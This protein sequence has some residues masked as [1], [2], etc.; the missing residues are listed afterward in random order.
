MKN[1][2]AL[3]LFSFINIAAQQ[4]TLKGTVEN[5]VTGEQL[6]FASIRIEG[7]SN[8]T[9]TNG[10]GNY[11]FKLRPGVYRFIASYIGF[12]SDTLK[13]NLQ[14]DGVYNFKLDPKGVNIAEIT[15]LPEDNPANEV[16]RRAIIVKNE[17]KKYLND[18]SFK[19]Y[20][21][22]LVKTTRDISVRRNQAS[23]SAGTKD[24]A[25]LKITG[26]IENDSRGYFK[27]PNYYKDEIIARKQSANTP[28]QVNIFTGGR[29]I[30]D[31]YRDDIQFMGRPLPSPISDDALDFY[32]FN[33][34]DTVSVDRI[35]VFKIHFSP[36]RESDPGFEGD[37]F[38]ADN[39]FALV[40]IDVSLNKAANFAGI[41]EKT[42]I[43]QQFY[44]YAD[45]I[46]MPVDYR[47]FVEGNALGMFKFGFELNT[48][49]SNYEINKN[50][51]DDF[52][53]MAIVKV[54][55]DADKK[56]STYWKNIQALPNTLAEV[57]AYKRIDSLQ[58]IPLTF[59]DRFS[60]LSSTIDLDD[61]FSISGPIGLYDFNKVEGHTLKFEARGNQLLD[62]R[63]GIAAGLRYGFNDKKYKAE[64]SVNYLFG[65]YRTDRLSFTLFNKVN[66]L[67]SSSDRYSDF[68]STFMNLFLKEDFR[69]YFYSKGFRI[70][71]SAEVFPIL[72]FGV[73]FSN[74]TDNTA[75]NNTNFSI[76][77][78][79]W[80][81]KPN[82]PV[83]DTKI[84]A[85]NFSFNLDYRNYIEDGYR[86]MRVSDSDFNFY[87]NGSAFI[88]DKNTLGS[89]DDF[90]IYGLNLN[91]NFR[92]YKTAYISYYAGGVLSK[93]AVP[94]QYLSNLPG[95]INSVSKDYSFRT[96][97]VNETFGDR[98]ATT[99][100]MLNFGDEFFRL[101]NVPLLKNWQLLFSM[102]LNAGWI[103]LA[104]S[105]KVP[106]G[107]KNSLYTKPLIEAGFGIGQ[108]VFPFRLEFTWRLTQWN[109]NGFV[110]SLNSNELL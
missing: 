71:Y 83:Y 5:K 45:D 93:D 3:L 27:K 47:I 77:R 34:V 104:N 89:N 21:K 72:R 86:R 58:A 19:A 92:V 68:T 78:Q 54:M 42:R 28:S 8:G 24:T 10:E 101:L 102:H 36:R 52:F 16:I 73:G 107:V 98:M 105:G 25:K 103:D 76:F 59:A 74:R 84:N 49:F 85:L 66:S 15:V 65:D 75:I 62:E 109:D 1:V 44:S 106:F 110:I 33:I 12:A 81:F 91:G 2:L 90:Q 95:N 29:I 7:T 55:P 9:T 32:Y 108:L 31:F 20:T 41:F 67:F 61:H 14:K 39:I 60:F 69:E 43:F 48:L 100:L 38:I 30:Q 97:R 40:K 56:D 4:Y 13:I 99:H 87:L 88:S 70:N 26:I 11:E 79:G 82:Y 94:F 35:N 53:G 6:S 23:V 96:L 37:I 17:R 64:F 46:Y 80:N 51:P 50:I 22:G 18:Y 63:F 57:K